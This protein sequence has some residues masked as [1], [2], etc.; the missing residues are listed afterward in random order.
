MFRYTMDDK[1]IKDRKYFHEK[2][3]LLNSPVHSSPKMLK[4]YLTSRSQPVLLKPKAMDNDLKIRILQMENLKRLEERGLVKRS[5]D[6]DDG[7]GS[8]ESRQEEANER[9]EEEGERLDREEDPPDEHTDELEEHPRVADD[10]VPARGELGDLPNLRRLSDDP[11]LA[12]SPDERRQ[13]LDDGPR[14]R[15][16]VEGG[17]PASDL[18]QEQ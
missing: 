13:M 4:F 16:P 6:P 1:R 12:A 8:Q 18:V 3:D 11:G 14:D 5:P 10:E 15:Q 2:H 17:R 9:H 7:R